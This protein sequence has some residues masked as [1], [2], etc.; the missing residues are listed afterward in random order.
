MYFYSTIV[1]ILGFQVL[2]LKPQCRR[3]G[4]L[5]EEGYD[6]SVA[7][8]RHSWYWFSLT[9]D[10]SLWVAGTPIPWYSN[11]LSPPN[12]PVT[13]KESLLTHRT[14]H[15]SDPVYMRTHGSTSRGLFVGIVWVTTKC[16][17]PPPTTPSRNGPGKIWTTTPFWSTKPKFEPSRVRTD[18]R[19]G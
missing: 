11:P 6:L 16:L 17:Y 13:Y 18:S 4:N 14:P 3:D 19:V 1:E 12:F 7:P 9:G 5:Y 10:R 2:S 8:S 15:D